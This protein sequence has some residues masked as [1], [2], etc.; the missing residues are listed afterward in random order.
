MKKAL[1]LLTTVFVVLVL[2]TPAIAGDADDLK[3][4]QPLTADE[5]PLYEQAKNDPSQLHD[6]IKTRTYLR[7][8]E[9]IMGAG[10]QT[11]DVTP[12]LSKFP[13]PSKNVN[14]FPYTVSLAE[15][16][17]LYKIFVYFGYYTP[18]QNK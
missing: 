8:V 17:L 5:Q 2:G 16:S 7:A 18:Q 1:I 9:N 11:K 13:K 14:F 10:W 12:Y 15:Q 6:F 4:L 3:K